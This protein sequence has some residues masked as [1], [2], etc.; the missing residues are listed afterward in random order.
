[1]LTQNNH[2]RHRR[3]SPYLHG[4]SVST[5]RTTQSRHGGVWI[6]RAGASATAAHRR[7]ER[8]LSVSRRAQLGLDILTDRLDLDFRSLSL[9]SVVRGHV[10]LSEAAVWLVRRFRRLQ[11][12]YVVM[13]VDW[14]RRCAGVPCCSR[15]SLSLGVAA[16]SSFPATQARIF[17]AARLSGWSRR[18]EPS[19]GL[20][21]HQRCLRRKS[22]SRSKVTGDYRSRI[23]AR[24]RLSCIFKPYG[25]IPWP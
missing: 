15:P 20:R 17:N 14:R 16:Q 11:A 3:R 13:L 12:T 7:T 6:E 25:V 1:M 8:S 18:L 22:T 21:I 5:V 4:K 24:V 2:G 9:D 10:E 23:S 19:V